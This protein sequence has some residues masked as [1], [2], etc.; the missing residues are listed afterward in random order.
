MSELISVSELKARFD[1]SPDVS[2][3]RL[4][5]AIG[6]AS[7]RIRKW[8]GDDN[9]TI[10]LDGVT[11]LEMSADLKNAESYL[12]MHFAVVGLNS[13]FSSKGVLASSKSDEGNESRTYLSPDQTAKLS[14]QFLEAAIEMAEP[15][16]ILD[17]IP[18]S[19]WEIA[20]QD[21]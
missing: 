8:V 4:I 7:R 18:S 6:S 21:G 3:T 20:N 11:D 19:T 12:A 2:D 9:Y 5:P 13:P 17:S 16:T 14:S 1:I 15:Y 10:A